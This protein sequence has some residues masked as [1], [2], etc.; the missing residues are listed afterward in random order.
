MRLKKEYTEWVKKKYSISHA[1]AC[2]ITGCCRTSKYYTLLMPE[3]DALLKEMISRVIGASRKGRNKVIVLLQRSNPNLSKSKIRRVYQKEGFSLFKRV[4]KRVSSN[5]ANPIILPFSKN[6]EWAMDFMSDSLTNGRRIRTLNIIDH[7]DRSC[8]AIEVEHSFPARKVTMI[9]DRIIEEKGKPQTIRTDN[10]P[11][12]TS[13]CFQLWLKQR[14][15][16]WAPIEKGAPQQNGIIERF[17]RTYREDVLD[18][19]VFSSITSAKQITEVF[20]E[21]YNNNRPHEALGN[22]TPKEYSNVA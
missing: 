6:V 1:L 14:K 4:K 22:K 18:A 17:N 12:F 8:L 15:I 19:N 20:I 7:F 10:G 3:K 2:K 21:D 16:K 5:P 11:E 9:L 13:K